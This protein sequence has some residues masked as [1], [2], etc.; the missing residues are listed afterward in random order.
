[1]ETFLALCVF[2]AGGDIIYPTETDKH[3]DDNHCSDMDLTQGCHQGKPKSSSWWMKQW[4]STSSVT[5]CNRLVV[6]STGPKADGHLGHLEHSPHHLHQPHQPQPEAKVNAKDLWLCVFYTN[7]G[8]S[9]FEHMD[10]T[11]ASKIDQNTDGNDAHAE[12]KIYVP[13]GAL[14]T[15]NRRLDSTN[16]GFTELYNS[17]TPYFLTLPKQDDLTAIMTV[18][19]PDRFWKSSKLSGKMDILQHKNVPVVLVGTR[20]Q[21]V[22]PSQ[23]R[24]T[25]LSAY[26]ANVL[27]LCLEKVMMQVVL[28]H[29]KNASFTIVC[30]SDS[31]GL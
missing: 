10:F 6:L 5:T 15:D 9:I 25:S 21:E 19:V 29:S 23:G 24:G 17:L 11:K 22:F 13:R 26:M 12:G 20:A 18:R 28:D 14:G 3:S 4:T 2:V 30:C 8:K 31:L 1:V 27:A 7:R 16:I